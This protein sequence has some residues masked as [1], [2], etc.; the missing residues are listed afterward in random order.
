MMQDERNNG[1]LY[2]AKYF[3]CNTMKGGEARVKLDQAEAVDFQWVTAKRASN[4]S[5]LAF[6][7]GEGLR[8]L[9]QDV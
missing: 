7:G 1:A 5:D 6:N 9:L 3:I 4:M 2:K 8:R